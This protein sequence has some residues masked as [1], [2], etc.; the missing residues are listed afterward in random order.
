MRG[1]TL[2]A[3]EIEPPQAHS[4]RSVSDRRSSPSQP[5]LNSIVGALIESSG[6]SLKMNVNVDAMDLHDVSPQSPRK[7]SPRPWEASAGGSHSAALGNP[8]IAVAVR[9]TGAGDSRDRSA[10]NGDA[11]RRGSTGCPDIQRRPNREPEVGRVNP[12]I[13]STD[14]RPTCRRGH[15]RHHKRTQRQH[16]TQAQHALLYSRLQHPSTPREPG[17]CRDLTRPGAPTYQRHASKPP[18]CRPPAEIHAEGQPDANQLRL[19]H[20]SPKQ[21]HRSAPTEV[22][23]Y[24]SA[25]M[26]SATARSVVLRGPGEV[27]TTSNLCLP[28]GSTACLP[29]LGTMPVGSAIAAS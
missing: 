7:E 19:G 9:E 22:D 21:P 2:R 6:L 10:V 12:A 4:S 18:R 20:S 1:Q 24:T 25:R 23:P 8:D 3:I 27:N 14:R 11:E 26:N 28:R 15:R 16:D 5:N 29:G 17:T 13:G